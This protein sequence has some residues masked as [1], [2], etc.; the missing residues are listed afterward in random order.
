MVYFEN[1]F[2][3]SFLHKDFPLFFDCRF[4]LQVSVVR[5]PA[6][7]TTLLSLEDGPKEY[8]DELELEL[9]QV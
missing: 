5:V 7:N 2:R 1:T 6:Q 3:C 8:V 4:V 9:E